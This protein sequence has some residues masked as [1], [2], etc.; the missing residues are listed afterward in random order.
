MVVVPTTRPTGFADTVLIF[1]HG[2]VARTVDLL[3]ESDR[4]DSVRG[5]RLARAIAD[6]YPAQPA[7]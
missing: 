7:A 3:E 1:D 2:C 5:E 4:S 6:L